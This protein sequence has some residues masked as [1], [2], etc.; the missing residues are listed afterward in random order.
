MPAKWPVIL[1]PRAADITPVIS[2][3]LAQPLL[4]PTPPVK[5]RHD[6]HQW[7]V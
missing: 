7:H 5:V 4:D 1:P 3:R 2:T 6:Q